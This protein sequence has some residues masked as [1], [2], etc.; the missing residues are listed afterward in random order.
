MVARIRP[1]TGLHVEFWRDGEVI[2]WDVGLTGERAL[3]IAIIMLA[4]LD[5]LQEH[6]RLTV[7]PAQPGVSPR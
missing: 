3:K 4:R 1:S 6:D 7:S 2:D 5:T